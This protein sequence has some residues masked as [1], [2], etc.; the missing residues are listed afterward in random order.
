ML[1]AQ[2]FI[3]C[4]ASLRQQQQ[5]QRGM[6]GLS[7]LCIPEASDIRCYA[8]INKGDKGGG[9]SA[10]VELEARRSALGEGGQK[11]ADQVLHA[12]PRRDLLWES[13][14]HTGAAK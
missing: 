13:T 1:G 4:I 10:R 7:S 5:K 14:H 9:G 3:P 11:Q 2:R 8:A 6:H 12:Q